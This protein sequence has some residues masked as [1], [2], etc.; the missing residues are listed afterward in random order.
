MQLRKQ[1]ADLKQA[2]SSKEEE[3]G[4]LKSSHSRSGA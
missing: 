4:V 2:L 1:V 3:L